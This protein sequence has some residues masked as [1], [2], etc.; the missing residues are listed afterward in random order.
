MSG[1]NNLIFNPFEINES[2]DTPLTECDPDFM[3]YSDTQYIQNTQCD[4]YI[5]DKFISKIASNDAYKQ[6]L[7]FYHHNIRSLPKHY[8]ELQIYINSLEYSFPFIGLGETRLDDNKENLYCL[9]GY[10]PCLLYTSDAADDP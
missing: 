1:F 6:S 2:I 9:E 4:Y 5:E 3:F 8:D 7:G 10:E